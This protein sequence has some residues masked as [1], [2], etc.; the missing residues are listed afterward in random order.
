MSRWSENLEKP[1]DRELSPHG[2]IIWFDQQG[3][4]TMFSP[5][6]NKRTI[7]LSLLRTS[8]VILKLMRKVGPNSLIYHKI[9]S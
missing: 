9:A 5:T 7:I 3:N 1:E 4:D 2:V 6:L 8:K